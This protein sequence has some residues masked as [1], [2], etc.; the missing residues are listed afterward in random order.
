MS[1]LMCKLARLYLELA[2]KKII[3]K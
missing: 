3:G 1:P 2:Q